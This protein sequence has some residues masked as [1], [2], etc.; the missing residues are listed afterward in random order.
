M[1]WRGKIALTGVALGA[2]GT[3]IA[4]K[5]CLP[6]HFALQ[7][8]SSEAENPFDRS[9][10]PVIKVSFLRCG[11][12]TVPEFIAVRGAASLALRTIAY[13]A[14]LIQHPQATFLY[15]TGLCTHID[16]F[17]K[18]Q[19]L[20]F[21]KTLGSYTLELPLAQH[22]QRIGMVLR[23]LDFVILS[24]LH[25]DHVSGIPDLPGIPLRVNRV[26]YEAARHGL[27][28][29]GHNLVPRLLGENPL[30][31]FDCAGPTYEGFRSSFDLFGD[32]S[33]ML[34]PLP[35]HTAGNTGL[36]INRANGSRLLLIGDAAWVAENYI[37]P[38]TMHPF[39]WSLVT[40]AIFPADTLRSLSLPCTMH[41]CKRHLPR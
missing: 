12:V 35:G 31:L 27:F 37:Q 36:F 29:Q 39:I 1:K 16:E 40:C 15:D 24:H 18:G 30:E 34:L 3:G 38:A 4:L 23:D 13:S 22:L 10:F 26:E 28:D 32:G 11:Y 8:I 20:F 7:H 41:R 2:L 14:V 6:Q 33:V 19:S 21:R 17:I 9:Q 25:W 5:S